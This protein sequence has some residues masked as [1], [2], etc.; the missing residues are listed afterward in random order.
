VVVAGGRIEDPPLALRTHPGPRLLLALLQH[1]PIVGLF[2]VFVGFVPRPIAAEP[3]QDRVLRQHVLDLELLTTMAQKAPA[4]ELHERRRTAPARGRTVYGHKPTASFDVTDERS[5]LL[6]RHHAHLVPVAVEHDGVVRREGRGSECTRG[7][8]AVGQV[9][10]IRTN[11][12]LEH[13]I[14][15][16][17]IMVRTIARRRPDKQDFEAAA[18]GHRRRGLRSEPT[19]GK[20]HDQ[21]GHSGH[22]EHGE[23]RA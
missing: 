12:A 4:N 23:A 7:I 13:A 6:L 21:Q 11:T 15:R 2:V 18:F 8:L 19:A 14:P 9:D 16:D 1:E 3:L 22:R 10:T 17:R 5:E 20:R